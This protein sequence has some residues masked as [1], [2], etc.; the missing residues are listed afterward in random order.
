MFK[1]YTGGFTLITAATF[2]AIGIA[3]LMAYHDLTGYVESTR[4]VR[5]TYEVLTSLETTKS[6]LK[7]AETGQRGYIITGD[8]RYL[9]RYS[10]SVDRIIPSFGR[11]FELTPDNPAQQARLRAME[12]AARAKLDEMQSVI[13]L[14]RDQ[15]FDAARGLVQTN[16]GENLMSD[17][18]GIADEIASSERAPGREGSPVRFRL[19][20]LRRNA[21]RVGGPDPLADLLLRDGRSRGESPQDGRADS[22]AKRGAVPHTHRDDSATHLEC[23]H[24]RH[25]VVLEPPVARIHRV[26][27]RRRAE[28]PLERDPAPRRPFACRFVLA[29]VAR[30]RQRC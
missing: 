1:K 22:S 2:S 13:E 10:G 20:P 4:W 25:T 3:G 28:R 27:Q 9:E 19:P 11:L 7:E 5:H 26:F 21:A 29:P 16:R 14:R 30:D 18:L 17:A 15:G 23:Q 12:K 24:R 6:L 8:P